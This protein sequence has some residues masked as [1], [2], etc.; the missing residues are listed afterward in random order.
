MK[1]MQMKRKADITAGA[2]QL[3]MLNLLVPTF[4]EDDI[5]KSNIINYDII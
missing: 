3:E 5:D 4:F 1:I 2:D